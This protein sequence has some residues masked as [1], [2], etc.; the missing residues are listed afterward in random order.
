M[1][2][3]PWKTSTFTDKRVTAPSSKLYVI[4]NPLIARQ[5][6]EHAP[7]VGLYVPVSIYVH[8]DERGT[9]RIGYDKVSPIFERFVN[10]KVNE[11]ARGL[12]QKLEELTIGA[13]VRV[14]IGI[15]IDRRYRKSLS[16]V[17]RRGGGVVANEAS[18][19]TCATPGRA[20]EA[21]QLRGEAR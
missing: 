21:T 15:F 17:G 14:A 3:E 19:D 6:L 7:Q 12:D 13:A 2:R 8:E 10:D 20:M 5:M 18:K 9:T 1:R 11:V 16:D 4:G